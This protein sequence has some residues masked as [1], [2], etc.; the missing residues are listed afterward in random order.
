MKKLYFHIGY[1]KTA[2]TFL[3]NKF[4]VSIKE[5]NYINL[6]NHQFY[7]FN[8][9]KKNKELLIQKFCKDI[10][11]KY[12]DNKTNIISNEI[13]LDPLVSQKEEDQFVTRVS[14]L[15]QNLEIIY[16]IKELLKSK[17]DIMTNYFITIRENH[18]LLLSY[19]TQINKSINKYQNY[20]ISNLE[21]VFKNEQFKDYK[22]YKNILIFFDYDFLLNKF[23]KKFGTDLKYFI[24]KNEDSKF[25]EYLSSINFYLLNKIYIPKVLLTRVNSS[26]K[27]GHRYFYLNNYKKNKI[28]LFL[29][30][31]IKKNKKLFN[32]SKIIIN[33]FEKKDEI[34]IKPD[35][36]KM[37]KKYYAHN[38]K[39]FLK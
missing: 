30:F 29:Y 21:K 35:L 22:L 26:D 31:L 25:I 18:M 38:K 3:Q 4:F 8:N 27:I 33:I 37:I 36:L 39:Y 16:K 7:F 15:E 10:N 20:N 12:L 13:F 1:P 17:F 34:K 9:P 24:Y 23:K 6:N 5:I 28:Y 19:F 11:D 14:S 2:T 32:L